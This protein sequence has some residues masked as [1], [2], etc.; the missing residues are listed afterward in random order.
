VPSY[1]ELQTEA[2]WRTQFV[3]QALHEHLIVPLRNHY[4]LGPISIG[5]P[6]DNNH[7]YG[8]HR[9]RNWALISRFCTNRSY[10]TT[11]AKDQAGNGDWYRAIDFGITGQPLYDAC[12]RLDAA[13]RAGQLPGVAEWFGTFDG[14]TVVGWY[15]GRPSSSDSS[16]LTHGH[17]GL[18]NESANDPELMKQ[19]FAVITGTAPPPTTVEDDDMWLIVAPSKTI[20][21]APGDLVDTKPV[22]IPLTDYNK[23]LSWRAGGVREVASAVEP[24]APYW[25]VTAVNAS[26]PP[27]APPV[28]VEL[29][30]EDIA[31]LAAQMAE[32]QPDPLTY[33]ET[34]KAAEEGAE[35]A[36]D[37]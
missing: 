11:H 34:V 8:R 37:R 25:F 17:V 31:E 23:V 24:K 29:S 9:S 19:L 20:Y 12:R 7:L 18:W 15:Q 28:E 13:V 6:G 33:D 22:A 35:L 27:P 2:V 3:P 26:W 14:R 1:A 16:H 36:S 21:L 4:G 30:D 32:L 5:A 10:G